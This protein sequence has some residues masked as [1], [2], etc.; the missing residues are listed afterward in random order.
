MTRRQQ[1]IQDLHFWIHVTLFRTVICKTFHTGHD[2]RSPNGQSHP[3]KPPLPAAW[4][5]PEAMKSISSIGILSV[6]TGPVSAMSVPA[7]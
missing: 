5:Q 4:S 6:Q 7:V 3:D 1:R 2:P